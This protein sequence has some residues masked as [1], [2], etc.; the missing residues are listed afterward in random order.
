MND[1]LD[2][3]TAKAIGNEAMLTPR[4]PSLFEPQAAT[5]MPA[6]FETNAIVEQSSARTALDVPDVVHPG[7]A[8]QRSPSPLESRADGAP[9][10][11]AQSQPDAMQRP[12]PRV[13]MQPAIETTLR[14]SDVAVKKMAQP[15]TTEHTGRHATPGEP[16]EPRTSHVSSEPQTPSGIAHAAETGVL[17]PPAKPVFVSTKNLGDLPARAAEAMHSRSIGAAGYPAGQSEP[18]VHVSIG[19][20]EVR[21]AANSA[22]TPVRRNDAP[23]PSSLD[24]YLRQRGKATP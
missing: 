11:Q 18:V 23:R 17:L 19:R 5:I 10:K 24:D 8:L 1:F 14:S 15:T 9:L 3:V 21:A 2:R 4:L 20:L 16:V 6:T 7:S 13:A 22:P 12:V